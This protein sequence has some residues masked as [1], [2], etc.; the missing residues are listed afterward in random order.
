MIGKEMIKIK[1]VSLGTVAEILGERE[2]EGEL[3]FEQQ[4]TLEYAKK[5]TKLEKEKREQLFNE[6]KALERM[7]D[8]AAVKIVDVL[9]RN[10]EQ[11]NAIFA[12][13]RYV[14]SQSE[15]EEVLRIV[16]KYVG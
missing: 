8:D 2:K 16:G 5:F 3:G 6:L 9:P 13:E 11:V 4:T 10:A 15:I 1:P 14:L 7:S 12:K